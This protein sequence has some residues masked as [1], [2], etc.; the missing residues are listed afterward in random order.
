[1][2]GLATLWEKHVLTFWVSCVYYLFETKWDVWF[3]QMQDS[4]SIDFKDNI[5]SENIII[6][7][8]V[9]NR[10]CMWKYES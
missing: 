9:L 3:V 10:Y 2:H 8:L 1:M 4:G 7:A 6:L 5:T